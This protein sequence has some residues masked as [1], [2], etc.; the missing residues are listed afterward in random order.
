MHLTFDQNLLNKLSQ[1]RY[2]DFN[3]YV[4]SMDRLDYPLHTII[5][6]FNLMLYFLFFILEEF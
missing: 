4:W 1:E 3:G 5:K 6:E 2:D